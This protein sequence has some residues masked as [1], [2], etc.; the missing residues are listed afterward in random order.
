MSLPDPT[1]PPAPIVVTHRPEAAR[2]EVD[3]DG[4]L[5]IATYQLDAEHR[6]VVFDHTGVPAVLQGRGIAAELV[7]SALAWAEAE[8]LQVVPRCS[9]VALYMRRHPETKPLLEPRG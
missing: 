6:R 5:S 3:T 8:R 1:S 7:R 2:F 9:Y 4:H